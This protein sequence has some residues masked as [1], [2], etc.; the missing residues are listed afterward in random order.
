MIISCLRCDRTVQTMLETVS[1][2]EGD[3]QTGQGDDDKQHKPLI[4]IRAE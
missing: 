1:G 3:P 2:R 4:P